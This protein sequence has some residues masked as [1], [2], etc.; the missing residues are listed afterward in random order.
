MYRCRYVALREILMYHVG[1]E[2]ISDVNEDTVRYAPFEALLIDQTGSNGVQDVSMEKN[3][4][5]SQVNFNL[6]AS[7][8]IYIVHM[9]TQTYAYI[10]KQAHPYSF[11]HIQ[12]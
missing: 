11:I 2:A 3:E 5:H 1:F 10:Y 7:T 12:I 8:Y 6:L 4:K 9:H